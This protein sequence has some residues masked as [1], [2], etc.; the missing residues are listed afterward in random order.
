M[1]NV[2]A[3]IGLL[4]AWIGGAVIV[5]KHFGRGAAVGWLII[6]A[7]APARPL[8]L[9]LAGQFRRGQ[10]LPFLITL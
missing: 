7:R 3:T 1:V 8:R 9:G 2:Y 6:G 10:I 5:G 4:A